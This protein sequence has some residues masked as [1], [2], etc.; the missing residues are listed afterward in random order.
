MRT[1]LTEQTNRKLTDEAFF[2][3]IEGI[4]KGRKIA[5]VC[6]EIGTDYVTFYEMLNAAKY[7]AP[8]KAAQCIALENKKQELLHLS[9]KLD[10]DDPKA[11]ATKFKIDSWI[12]TKLKSD[13]FGDKLTV[14]HD[15]LNLTTAID[16][17][18]KRIKNESPSDS[19][20]KLI[21]QTPDI[22]EDI[23]YRETDSESVEEDIDPF[24]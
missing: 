5:D 18:L 11:I 16:K 17:A 15:V 9:E 8:Y 3:V 23:E 1:A 19:A 7:K 6:Q 10:L 2:K 22:I 13:E 20:S 21:A 12:L 24:S 4:K 14:Q